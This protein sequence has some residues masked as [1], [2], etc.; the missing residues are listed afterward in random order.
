MNN[1]YGQCPTCGQHDIEIDED[2][3]VS[4]IKEALDDGFISLPGWC[5][6]CKSN[7]DVDFILSFSGY[8]NIK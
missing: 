6:S 1:S 2:I 4:V 5:N 8:T 3:E 7:F